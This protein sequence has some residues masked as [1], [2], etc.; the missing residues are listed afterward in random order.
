M[1]PS[2]LSQ[3]QKSV[4]PAVSQSGRD[5]GP[6]PLSSELSPA[7]FSRPSSFFPRWMLFARMSPPGLSIR[8]VQGLPT[9]Y[10]RV[11]RGRAPR[12]RKKEAACFIKPGHKHEAGITDAVCTLIV[13]AVSELPSFKKRG[14]NPHLSMGGVR[15]ICDH[16][17][18]TLGDI[19]QGFANHVKAF[20]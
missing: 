6:F 14:H 16:F 17:Y 18:S 3:H 10:V 19:M 9:W 12:D 5:S 15:R 8:A 2:V 13:K 11:S 20:E 7:V 4:L 1:L